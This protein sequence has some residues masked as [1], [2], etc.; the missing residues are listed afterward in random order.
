MRLPTRNHIS[1]V[2]SLHPSR[3]D[4]TTPAPI[5]ETPTRE[6]TPAPEVISVRE[7]STS[8]ADVEVLPVVATVSPAPVA[9]PN[10]P[11]TPKTPKKKT[12]A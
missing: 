2:R 12:S 10:T 8:V 9:S 1:L 11:K 4:Q 6:V 7:V 3:T 5:V